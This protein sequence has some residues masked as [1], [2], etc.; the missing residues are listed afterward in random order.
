MSGEKTD[1]D[2]EFTSKINLWKAEL[3]K[4]ALAPVFEFKALRSWPAVAHPHQ[5]RL[6]A[7]RA[8]P[9]LVRELGESCT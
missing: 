1:L 2:S 9:S 5:D 6:E 7:A 3:S 8:I 4:P